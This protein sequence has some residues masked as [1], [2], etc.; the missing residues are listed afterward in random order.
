MLHERSSS[1]TQLPPAACLS[2]EVATPPPCKRSHKSC[3]MKKPTLPTD[4]INILFN[5]VKSS[6]FNLGVDLVLDAV[7]SGHLRNCDFSSKTWKLFSVCNTW[8]INR[9]HEDKDRL[10]FLKVRYMNPH[11]VAL[12][13]SEKIIQIV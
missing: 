12:Q 6:I 5:A 4:V 8:D 11:I 3:D 1:V 10:F 13:M 7:S 9:L 2:G